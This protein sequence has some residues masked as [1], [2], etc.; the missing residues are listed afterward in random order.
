MLNQGFVGWF[1]AIWIK[2]GVLSRDYKSAWHFTDGHEIR[3]YTGA[4]AI[5]R[6]VCGYLPGDITAPREES[7]EPDPAKLPGPV[8]ARCRR[9]IGR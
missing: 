6:A 1:R 7:L 8:C 9:K 5:P 3:R 4:D 2:N